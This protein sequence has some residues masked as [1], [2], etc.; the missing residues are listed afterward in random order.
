MASKAFVLVVDR[1]AF[2]GNIFSVL[3]KHKAQIEGSTA[4]LYDGD[5]YRWPEFKEFNFFRCSEVPKGENRLWTGL[6]AF[7]AIQD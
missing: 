5:A 6:R 2:R 7:S 3:F 4:A 1:P